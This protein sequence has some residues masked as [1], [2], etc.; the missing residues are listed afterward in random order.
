MRC[1]K[2]KTCFSDNE[3]TV[4]DTLCYQVKKGLRLT[5]TTR[6]IILVRVALDLV[7]TLAS[8]GSLFLRSRVGVKGVYCD[9]ALCCVLLHNSIQLRLL[10]HGNAV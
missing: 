3:G 8:C 5:F 6:T 10:V 1:P 4:V 7:T 2:C 9:T